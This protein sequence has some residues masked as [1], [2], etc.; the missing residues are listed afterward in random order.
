MH[1][2]LGAL[3]LLIS[4]CL[5]SYL[6]IASHDISK[7]VHEWL[8]IVA[9]ILFEI[10]LIIIVVDQVSEYRERR[11]W[12]S[13]H[14][15]MGQTLQRAFVDLVRVNYIFM[16]PQTRDAVRLAE[17]I[18]FAR[19]SLSDLRSQ[20]ESFTS[21]LEAQKQS[22]VRSIEK[23]LNYL[24]RNFHSLSLKS[25]SEYL[26]PNS[27]NYEN[28]IFFETHDNWRTLRD[29]SVAI[30]AFLELIRY[31]RDPRETTTARKSVEQIVGKS[32]KTPILY[33]DFYS[34]RYRAQ[35]LAIK[36]MQLKYVLLDDTDQT[37][38]LYF[39]IDCLLL[40][41]LPM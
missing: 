26:P 10:F 34:V 31:K 7:T 27:V 33:R 12:K 36:E 37:N 17:F 40:S 8:M 1:Y 22:H 28:F 11:K 9:G 18:D 3:S 4:V 20:I 38:S 21:S 30:D 15:N 16:H 5:V 13:L 6:I 32:R 41:K 29:V 19:F 24:F 39:C 2:I 23:R 35:D 25:V 14:A